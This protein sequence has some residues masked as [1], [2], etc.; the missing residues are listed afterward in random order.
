[1]VNIFI[2][3]GMGLL[4]YLCID[5]LVYKFRPSLS[6]SMWLAKQILKHSHNRIYTNSKEKE[7]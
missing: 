4:L 6:P 1:M 2:V 7:K 3:V 5:M